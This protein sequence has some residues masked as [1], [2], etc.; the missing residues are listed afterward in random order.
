MYKEEVSPSLVFLNL[1][2]YT[3]FLS[4][5]N[6]SHLSNPL[7]FFFLLQ[8]S[9]ILSRGNILVGSYFNLGKTQGGVVVERGKET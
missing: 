2:S 4:K 6:S 1:N 8:I 9:S 3:L 5:K 7:N